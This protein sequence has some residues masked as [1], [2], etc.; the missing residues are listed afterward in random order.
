LGGKLA[1]HILI[2]DFERIENEIF[3]EITAIMKCGLSTI[4]W[5]N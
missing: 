2:L 5:V 4:K 1:T 3:T